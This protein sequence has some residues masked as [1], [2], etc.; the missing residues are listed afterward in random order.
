M[1][2]PKHVQLCGPAAESTLSSL[3]DRDGPGLVILR[4]E[5]SVPIKQQRATP[6][7]PP[8]SASLAAPDTSSKRHH[9][10]LVSVAGSLHLAE[11]R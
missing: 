5:S 8:G 6:V 9:A 3:R 1:G 4:D 11:C 10:G 7:P 2:R